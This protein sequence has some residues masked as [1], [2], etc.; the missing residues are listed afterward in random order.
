MGT[1]PAVSKTTWLDGYD[2]T[3]DLNETELNLEHDVLDA[4]VFVSG[5][6]P[7]GRVRQAGLQSV[8]SKVA[9]L[10]WSDTAVA[11]DPQIVNGLATGASAVVT[12][13]VAGTLGDVA[14]LYTAK[15]L[16]YSVFGKAGELVPFSLDT[17]GGRMP[18]GV[19]WVGAVRGVVA[20]GKGAVSATGAVG[21]GVQLGAV[22]AGKYLYATVHVFTAG[23]TITLKVESDD[24]SGFTTPTSRIATIGPITAV[25]GVWATRV[26]GPITDTYYRFNVT[27][28]TGSYS[29]A[30][31][32]GI[33]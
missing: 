19:P 5:T 17:Q 23:T 3:G 10:W 30:G 18:G 14:Y 1:G 4:T 33:K 16:A 22:G 25:G 28:V 31:A 24:N 13:S 15:K 6:G 8:A 29:L 9:G 26:A 11:P 20:A 32:I 12:Q 2:L 7:R 27:A 21:A